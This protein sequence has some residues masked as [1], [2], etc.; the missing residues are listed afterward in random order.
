MKTFILVSVVVIAVLMI[1]GLPEP[2]GIYAV[3]SVL[4]FSLMAG[5]IIGL[6]AYLIFRSL[7]HRTG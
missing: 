2:Y 7:F 6:F 1:R 4:I 3:V 5:V